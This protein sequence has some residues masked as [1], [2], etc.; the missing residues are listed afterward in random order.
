MTSC[1]GIP[2]SHTVDVDI[3]MQTTLVGVAL[4]RHTTGWSI[5]LWEVVS[6]A[7]PTNSANIDAAKNRVVNVEKNHQ[8]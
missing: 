8:R 6:A 4:T 3:T 5:L 2:S 7:L 1:I